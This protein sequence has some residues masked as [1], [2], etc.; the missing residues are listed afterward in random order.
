VAAFGERR[1]NAERARGPDTG[2][3]AMQLFVGA[4]IRPDDVAGLC[5]RVC[6]LL[7]ATDA[8]RIV[9]DVAAFAHPDA[10]VVDALARLQLAAKRL[11]RTIELRRAGAE[12]RALLALTGLVGVMSFAPDDDAS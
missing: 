5:A 3:D 6:R 2:T 8:P 7:D 1:S 12:L 11:G 10:A 9:L 4:P